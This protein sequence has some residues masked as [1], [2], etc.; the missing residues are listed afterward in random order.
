MKDM[1][2]MKKERKNYNLIFDTKINKL[3]GNRRSTL[4]SALLSLSERFSL[5]VARLSSLA[6]A[7]YPD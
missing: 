4:I 2:G 5:I 7:L 1:Y 3:K 6:I